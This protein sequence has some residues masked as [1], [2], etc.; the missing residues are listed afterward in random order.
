[1]PAT[2]EPTIT[3]ESLPEVA[4]VAEL[5]AYERVDERTLRKALEAGDVPGAFRRG[6]TWRIVT[7]TYL[8]AIDADGGAQ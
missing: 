4:T 1:M 3:R 6:R 5:A 2:R 8:G 7:R